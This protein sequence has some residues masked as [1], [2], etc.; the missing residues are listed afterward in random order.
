MISI[1]LTTEVLEQALAAYVQAFNAEPWNDGWTRSAAYERLR[2]LIRHPDSIAL[3]ATESEAVLGIACGW[4]ERWLTSDY[5]HLKEM[6]VVPKNQREG[7]GS[8]LLVHL[9]SRLDD[10]GVEE[11]YLDTRPG[12]PAA[13]FF[14]KHG[15]EVLNLQSM[16]L[17]VRI[18]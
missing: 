18:A 15:F 14:E 5:F 13:D 3:A 6:R 8:A 9:I 17:D 1:D 7:I 10:L 4:S 16:Y 11:C 2:R 12:T